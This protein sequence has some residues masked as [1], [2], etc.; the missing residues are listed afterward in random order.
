MEHS[1]EVQHNQSQFTR[2]E[3]KFPRI[4][5]HGLLMLL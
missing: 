3:D 4:I 5:H 1:I 2:L